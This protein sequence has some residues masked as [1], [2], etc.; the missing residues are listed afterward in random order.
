MRLTVLTLS[1][2][3]EGSPHVQVILQGVVHVPASSAA[4]QLSRVG[5]QSGH[6]SLAEGVPTG[7]DG[8]RLRSQTF[9]ACDSAS[10]PLLAVLPA[11]A[12]KGTVGVT[13]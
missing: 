1:E 4:S 8:R 9:I 12:G 7:G 13:P 2:S 5:L 10:A 6:R 3:T 11:R